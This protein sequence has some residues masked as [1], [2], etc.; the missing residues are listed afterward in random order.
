VDLETVFL[1]PL[2]SLRLEQGRATPFFGNPADPVSMMDY[3]RAVADAE[4]GFLTVLYPKEKGRRNLLV[5][6]EPDG[7]LLLRTESHSVGINAA[8]HPYGLAVLRQE[9]L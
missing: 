3:I 7:T 9:Q 4:A 2:E 6:M 5:Q 8:S 1:S